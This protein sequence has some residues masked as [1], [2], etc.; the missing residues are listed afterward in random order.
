[1]DLTVSISGQSFVCDVEAVNGLDA[2]EYASAVG[3]DIVASLDALV[4]LA[5]AGETPPFHLAVVAKWLALRQLVDPLVTFAAVA[6]ATTLG[7]VRGE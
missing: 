4:A 2:W 3:G 7:G 6:A 5:E 1:M